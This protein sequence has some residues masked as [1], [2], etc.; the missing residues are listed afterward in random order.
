MK[1]QLV[2]FVP[3]FSNMYFFVGNVHVGNLH[4]GES[5]TQVQIYKVL[6]LPL[7]GSGMGLVYIVFGS[8]FLKSNTWGTHTPNLYVSGSHTLGGGE[9]GMRPAHG[10]ESL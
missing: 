3:A 10:L 5:T 4:L 7:L 8:R 9:V 6:P 1:H 2:I